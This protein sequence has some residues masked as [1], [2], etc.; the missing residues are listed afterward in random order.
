VTQSNVATATA[1][2]SSSSTATQTA[3]VADPAQASSGDQSSSVQQLIA[4]SQVVQASSTAQQQDVT[5]FN[6]VGAGELESILQANTAD[7]NAVATA[8]FVAGQAVVQ[9]QSGGVDGV[10]QLA[11]VDQTLANQ[12]IAQASANAEQSATRNASRIWSQTPSTAPIGAIV[13]SNTAT[14]TAVAVDQAAVQ[15]IA[16]QTQAGAGQEQTASASQSFFNSQ[17]AI[18]AASS[19]Q[20][21]IANLSDVLIPAGGISNPSSTQTNDLSTTAVASNNGRG[22]QTVIQAAAGEFVEWHETATQEGTVRQSGDAGSGVV[23][24]DRTNVTGWRGQIATPSSNPDSTPAA[25]PVAQ[26]AVVSATTAVSPRGMFIRRVFAI[27][28]PS[29]TV[30]HHATPLRTRGQAG[31][32]TGARPLTPRAVR[33][34]SSLGSPR[35]PVVT[36]VTSSFEPAVVPVT[37]LATMRSLGSDTSGWSTGRSRGSEERQPSCPQSCGNGTLFGL[38]FAG[39]GGATYGGFVVALT[40]FRVFAAPGAGWLLIEAPDL[41]RPADTAPI[42]HP[43]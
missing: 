22:A 28:L 31:R 1:Q 43:G 24:V 36:S 5:N 41:G 3:T 42:E 17:T 6:F 32:R 35:K 25:A 11:D 4:G 33:V 38:A 20:V 15:Q 16:F 27:R 26:A 19:S 18:A 14:A 21:R 23:A 39:A 30:R 2:A 9:S 34:T 29:V 8:A 40:P 13:Q 12:Q 10:V 37:A 7:A